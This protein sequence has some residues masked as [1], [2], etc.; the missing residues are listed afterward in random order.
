MRSLGLGPSAQ[1]Q[2]FFRAEHSA[3][4]ETSAHASSLCSISTTCPLVRS[5]AEPTAVASAEPANASGLESREAQGT[6]S[7]VSLAASG[8]SSGAPSSVL[9]RWS[10]TSRTEHPSVK[11]TLPLDHKTCDGS[12]AVASPTGPSSP[13]PPGT[14]ISPVS[15]NELPSADKWSL[16]TVRFA[17]MTAKML[18]WEA[19]SAA[20][21]TAKDVIAP[22]RSPPSYLCSTLTM[23][24]CKC[25]LKR[26]AG[27]ARKS[28][29]STHANAV[30][31]TASWNSPT[32]WGL[33]SAEMRLYSKM[34]KVP[35]SCARTS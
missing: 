26:L 25:K 9:T 3:S 12:W 28:K 23:S 35:P 29:W 18:A 30:A 8:Q 31:S 32:L 16:T 34:D 14:R 21:P 7:T 19:T 22:E 33:R 6:G 1:P 11:R 15:S 27:D 17:G 5:S 24:V 20:K 13:S 2:P 10:R 4:A